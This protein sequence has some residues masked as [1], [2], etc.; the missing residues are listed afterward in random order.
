MEVLDTLYKAGKWVFWLSLSRRPYIGEDSFM[1]RYLLLLKD[2]EII[3]I[4][5]ISK[6][7]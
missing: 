1:L 2:F 3:V 4:Q 7:S 6:T 5:R